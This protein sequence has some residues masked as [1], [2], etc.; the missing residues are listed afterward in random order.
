M[1][2]SAT[3]WSSVHRRK[4]GPACGRRAGIT[5]ARSA[6]ASTVS[7]RRHERTAAPKVPAKDPKRDGAAGAAAVVRAAREVYIRRVMHGHRPTLRDLVARL[8][9]TP[10][11]ARDV[12]AEECMESLF[13][14]ERCG[15]ADLGER[16]EAGV[17]AERRRWSHVA[18]S[19]AAAPPSSSSG[20]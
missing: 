13:D 1:R 12:H 20:L 6:D 11:E 2:N 5:G 8:R 16:E 4:S 17:E 7:L 14:R 19:D 10:D 9:L 15:C 18:P 3:S